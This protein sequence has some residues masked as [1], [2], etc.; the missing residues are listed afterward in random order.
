MKTL[1]V[2]TAALALAVAAN[3]A[4]AAAQ[5]PKT[6]D[7][8]AWPGISQRVDN[9]APDAI[10]TTSH[11]EYEYGYDHHGAWRGRWVLVRQSIAYRKDFSGSDGAGPHRR[12]HQASR[13]LPAGT[14]QLPPAVSGNPLKLDFRCWLETAFSG[15]PSLRERTWCSSRPRSCCNKTIADQAT[16]SGR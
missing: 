5:G 8:N 4:P 16:Q 6:S 1:S 15:S 10:T 9:G 12:T 13:Q 2:A 7:D 3:L 11:Y 14:S